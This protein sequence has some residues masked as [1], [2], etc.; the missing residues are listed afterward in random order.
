MRERN[1]LD[2]EDVEQ[3]RLYAARQ[4]AKLESTRSI[5]KW[6]ITGYSLENGQ[7]KKK[8]TFKAINF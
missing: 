6:V 4:A 2:T 1:V 8:H 3:A 7:W 5:Q